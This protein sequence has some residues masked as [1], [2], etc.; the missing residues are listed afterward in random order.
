MST[1]QQF[2]L[3]VNAVEGVLTCP[4][5]GHNDPVNTLSIID[6]RNVEH[7]FTNDH[8]SLPDERFR[9]KVTVTANSYSCEYHW[10]PI[11]HDPFTITTHFDPVQSV[12]IQGDSAVFFELPHQRG[13]R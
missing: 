10:G 13:Q 8:S 9:F 5:G 4:A 3:T 7:E 11:D 6:N 2:I 12:K 1:T